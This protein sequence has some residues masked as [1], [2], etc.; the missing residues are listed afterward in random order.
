MGGCLGCTDA[1]LVCIVELQRHEVDV[2]GLGAHG[3][4]LLRL[5]LSELNLSAGTEGEDHDV[6]AVGVCVPREPVIHI[7]EAIAEDIDDR[8]VQVLLN[9]LAQCLQSCQPCRAALC[10]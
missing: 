4:D 8:A 10:S 7:L 9:A 6:V 1:V 5:E 3:L 2:P